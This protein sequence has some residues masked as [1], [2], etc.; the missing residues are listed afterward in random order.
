MKKMIKKCAAVI[1]AGFFVVPISFSEES[2]A[3]K[4]T[5]TLSVDQAVEYALKNNRT[6]KSNDIDLEIKKRAAKY[7]W[8]VF[9]PSVQATGTAARTTDIDST[10]NQMNMMGDLAPNFTPMT[11]EEKYHWALVGG[12]GASLNL[13]LAYIQNIRA[14]KADY[15][16]GAISWEKSQ[17]E[18]IVNI[19]KLF[20]GLLVQQENLKIEQA[21][22]E[23]A[24]QR[25]IQ[26]E[27]NFR[28]GLVSR[29]QMLQ[30][31]VNYEN[32]KPNV[33][34][35]ERSFRQ[36][37]DTFAF[38]IGMPVGTEIILEGSV[39]PVYVTVDAD[40]LLEK[41]GNESLDLRAM[42]KNIDMMKMKLSALNLSSYTPALSLNY[43]FQPTKTFF[44]D[45]S[46]WPDQGS[47][48]VT[49][50][51]NLTNM[52]PFSA[53]RQQAGDLKANIAKLE[54]TMET[55][56]E[57]QKMEVRKAVDTLNQAKEQIDSMGRTVSVAQEAYDM[58][59]RSYRNGTMEL[60]DLRDAENSLNQAKLGLLS[61]K[62][63][64]ISALMDLENTLNVTLQE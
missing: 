11:D 37:L 18:T 41:Y 1:F 7:S 25:Y 21:T 9:L 34:D 32:T 12:I 38:M 42:Q 19:K 5:V 47:F 23:N 17:A 61:R 50:A 24:R 45:D 15:E 33:E 16:A 55:L 8:N 30:T 2:D 39:E 29:I 56:K 54:I 63:S 44:T 52:L 26:A 51:W 48:S 62:M 36:Q 60:L 53:N 3:E 46:K 35:A 14:A 6:L 59:A 20:Y 22:L 40:E 43:N 4:K 49:L 27:T 10:L 57:N 31:Q 58:S 64:Y 28:N 13:S